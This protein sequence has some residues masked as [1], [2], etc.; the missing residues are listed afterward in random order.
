V[1]VDRE[2]DDTL[3]LTVNASND[4]FLVIS[5]TNAPGWRARVDGK[6]IDVL[7]ADGV[8][9]AVRVPAGSHRVALRYLPLSFAIGATISLLT[10]AAL[11]VAG[12]LT[13]RRRRTGRDA[14]AATKTAHVTRM[15]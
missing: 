5:Q 11:A 13:I 14:D 8:L 9:Q 1:H 3:A 10:L 6:N 15:D 4:S 12:A 2:T 7:A